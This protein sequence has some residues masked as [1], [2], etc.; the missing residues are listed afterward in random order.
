MKSIAYIDPY[1]RERECGLS[2]LKLI[3]LAKREGWPMRRIY[4]RLFV[5][6]RAYRQWLHS[7]PFIRRSGPMFTNVNTGSHWQYCTSLTRK[8]ALPA[9]GEDRP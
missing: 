7:Q 1:G 2:R 5:G 4:G 3:N 9:A 8:A 6:A